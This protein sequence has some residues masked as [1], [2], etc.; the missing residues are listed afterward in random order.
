[1]IIVDFLDFSCNLFLLSEN[2][3]YDLGNLIY[4]QRIFVVERGWVFNESLSMWTRQKNHQRSYSAVVR[5][6]PSHQ[7][8]RRPWNFLVL[9]LA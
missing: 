9:V 7:H 4:I 2:N 8:E 1:M 3:I 6:I 5:H